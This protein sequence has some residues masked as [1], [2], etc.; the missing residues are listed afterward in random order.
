MATIKPI[1]QECDFDPSVA[2]ST[3]S[4]E[5][6]FAIEGC[7]NTV[8]DMEE[9]GGL[10]MRFG[11]EEKYIFVPLR[12]A[13]T[14]TPIAPVLFTADRDE[15]AKIILPMFKRG[16]RQYASFHTHPQFAPYPSHIDMTRLFKGFLVN[17][18]YSGTQNKLMRY[19][20]Y[21]PHDFSEGVQIEEVEV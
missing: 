9:R 17:Y 16:W 19:E 8:E 21:N 13:N 5:L 14:G 10:V 4:G 12:N 6:W 20:W 18:I 11:D 2:P 3:L 15:Y 7:W 1:K